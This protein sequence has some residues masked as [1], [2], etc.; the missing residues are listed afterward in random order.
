MND[1]HAINMS[2]ENYN[3]K[4][5]DAVMDLY[6]FALFFYMNNYSVPLIEKPVPVRTPEQQL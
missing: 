2:V 5:Y 1:T 6:S 4:S 3:K